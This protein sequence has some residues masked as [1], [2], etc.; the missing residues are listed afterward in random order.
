MSYM[1]YHEIKQEQEQEQERKQ[2]KRPLNCPNCGAVVEGEKCAYCGT[3][4][5]DFAAIQMGAPSYVKFKIDDTYIMA[6]LVVTNLEIEQK[7]ETMD[8]HDGLD[9]IIGQVVT[10][11]SCDFHMD[12]YAVCSPGD[13][14]V[15]IIKEQ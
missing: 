12:A 11:A 15:T 9:R 4:F 1:E 7:Q 6:R 5:L 10:S 14:L 2:K 8:Y 13:A 3:V